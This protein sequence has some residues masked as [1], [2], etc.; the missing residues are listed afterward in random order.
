MKG[1]PRFRQ[2]NLKRDIEI[3]RLA[4]LIVDLSMT[5]RL[6]NNVVY[7]K[8]PKAL[9]LPKKY[10]TVEMSIRDMATYIVKRNNKKEKLTK[11]S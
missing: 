6:G 2:K 1:K 5:A 7:N 8:L 4:S 11:K 9:G 3:D 10:R